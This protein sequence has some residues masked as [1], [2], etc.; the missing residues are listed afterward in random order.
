MSAD[1]SKT[2]VPA[3][4]KQHTST[5]IMPPRHPSQ[6]ESFMVVNEQNMDRTIQ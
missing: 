1:M 3:S 4:N 5:D 2:A 6:T